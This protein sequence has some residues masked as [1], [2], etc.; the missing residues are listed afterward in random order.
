[1][2]DIAHVC[3]ELFFMFKLFVFDGSVKSVR[4]FPSESYISIPLRL[5]KNHQTQDYEYRNT[6]I[7]DRPVDR[8]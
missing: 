1:M 4:K 7:V 8:T 2:W 3:G 6:E 5:A